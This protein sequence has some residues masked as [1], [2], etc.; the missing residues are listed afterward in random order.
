VV[1]HE[2]IKVIKIFS[3]AP[4]EKNGLFLRTGRHGYGGGADR[5]LLEKGKLLLQ[6]GHLFSCVHH[7]RHAAD[8]IY[9]TP[10]VSPFE[11]SVSYFIC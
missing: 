5:D 2:A 6:N 7:R 3:F 8:P 10:S 9:A 1:L 4:E 11:R